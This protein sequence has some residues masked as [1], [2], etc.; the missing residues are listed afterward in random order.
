M[1][2]LLPHSKLVPEQ[3]LEPRS[4]A[5]KPDYFLPSHTFLPGAYQEGVCLL[6]PRE[7][8]ECPVFKTQASHLL[9]A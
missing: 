8:R 1:V 5:P 7:D 9:G 4:L 2:Q 3:H 6:A